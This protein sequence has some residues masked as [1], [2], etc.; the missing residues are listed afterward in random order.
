M[1]HSFK[2]TLLLA[3]I[4]GLSMSNTHFTFLQDEPTKVGAAVTPTD[5]SLAGI[6]ITT[7]DL[8]YYAFIKAPKATTHL[9]KFSAPADDAEKVTITAN[10]STKKSTDTFDSAD[11]T[12]AATADIVIGKGTITYTNSG[13]EQL[14]LVLITFKAAPT[15]AVTISTQK[16]TIQTLAAFQ[17]EFKDVTVETNSPLV[18]KITGIKKLTES[19][20]NLYVTSNA[21]THTSF[22][23]CVDQPCFTIA[24]TGA[25]VLGGDKVELASLLPIVKESFTDTSILYITLTTTSLTDESIKIQV[26]GSND[27]YLYKPLSESATLTYSASLFKDQKVIVKFEKLVVDTLFNLSIISGKVD[28]K[29][30]PVKADAPF[31]KLSDIAGQIG[32]SKAV[33]YNK[34]T[35][36][37]SYILILTATERFTGTLEYVKPGFELDDSAPYRLIPLTSSPK[38]VNSKPTI[39]GFKISQ[40][41]SLKEGATKVKIQNGE[42]KDLK[43]PIVTKADNSITNVFSFEGKPAVRIVNQVGFTTKDF[44]KQLSVFAN[45]ATI[46]A[47]TQDNTLIHIFELDKDSNFTFTAKEGVLTLVDFLVVKKNIDGDLIYIPL[48]NVNLN[49]KVLNHKST[50][51]EVP[52][53]PDSVAFFVVQSS[54][55]ATDVTIAYDSKPAS[56][57]FLAV[58]IIFVIA[59]FFL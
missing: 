29:L 36:E 37:G 23:L 32:D 46:Q 17:T 22:K 57:N 20:K 42:E 49:A 50:R 14:L 2:I 54:L 39:P 11:F 16:L 18:Y 28:A 44:Y 53:S 5:L 31:A 24:D 8:A 56:M 51:V 15:A 45:N 43:D 27:F 34:I 40:E 35:T 21:A 58:G 38:T 10:F 41:I 26:F 30:G 59:L 3:A 12:G 33:N 6:S 55:D 25:H 19:F 1:K 4:I 7:T 13:E 47:K 48:N 52:S 9:I